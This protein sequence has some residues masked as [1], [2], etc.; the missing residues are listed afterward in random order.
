MMSDL[1]IP[2]GTVLRIGFEAGL[3]VLLLVAAGMAWRLDRRLTAL[4]RGSHELGQ[5]VHELARATEVA[6]ATLQ[7]LRAETANRSSVPGASP[8][9]RSARRTPGAR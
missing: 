8:L 7:G 1:G 6:Q 5:A 3:F 4:K 9:A 2:A